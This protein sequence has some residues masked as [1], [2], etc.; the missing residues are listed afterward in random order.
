MAVSVPAGR[1]ARWRK[2][3][4]LHAAL[5][6]LYRLR[7][8]AKP[9]HLTALATKALRSGHAGIAVTAL[10]FLESRYQEEG[11][12]VRAKKVEARIR[13]LRPITRPAGIALLDLERRLGVENEVS[14]SKQR[15]QVRGTLAHS[16]LL[17]I[18]AR[19]AKT[20]IGELQGIHQQA[21]SDGKHLEAALCDILLVSEFR[22]TGNKNGEKV[23]RADLETLERKFGVRDNSGKPYSESLDPKPKRK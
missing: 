17:A 20:R 8:A 18:Y 15:E 7:E 14:P 1:D 21:V 12:A 2:A 16:I 22:R 23:A 5:L 10:I 9:S 11:A 13:A 3:I 4:A 6:R 19:I